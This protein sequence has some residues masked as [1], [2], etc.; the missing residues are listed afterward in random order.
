MKIQYV[1]DDA[2]ARIWIT[3]PF[4]Q[5]RKAKKLFEAGKSAAPVNSISSHGLTFQLTLLGARNH[6]LRAYKA[7]VAESRRAA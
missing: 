1:D 2:Y 3:G 5:L 6:T 4:W 7:I